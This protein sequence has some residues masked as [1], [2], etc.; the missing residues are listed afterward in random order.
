[1]NNRI[2]KPTKRKRRT[3]WG[4]KRARTGRPLKYGDKK[5]VRKTVNFPEEDA[6]VLQRV[7]MKEELSFSE[8]VVKLVKRGMEN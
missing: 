2:I 1:M 3:N 6:Q 5:P 7:R 8:L 4:G